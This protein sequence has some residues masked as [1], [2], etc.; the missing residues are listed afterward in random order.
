MSPQDAVGTTYPESIRIEI[1]LD[2]V[3]RLQLTI[4]HADHLTDVSRKHCTAAHADG[5]SRTEIQSGPGCPRVHRCHFRGNT[6]RMRECKWFVV[7]SD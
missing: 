1:F 5:G 2:R 6:R 4:M 7:H 3:L